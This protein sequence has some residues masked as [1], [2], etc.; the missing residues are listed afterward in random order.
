MLDRPAA[1]V[2]VENFAMPGICD[3]NRRRAIDGLR[4]APTPRVI[5]VAGGQ[6][7]RARRDQPAFGSKSCCRGRGNQKIMSRPDVTCSP[8]KPTRRSPTDLCSLNPDFQDLLDRLWL[9][10]FFK[11]L[12]DI[13]YTYHFSN[14]VGIMAPQ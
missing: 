12:K 11:S 10:R 13:L 7:R 1:A 14:S 6:A 9:H 2:I 3:V 5:G 4:L 8:R